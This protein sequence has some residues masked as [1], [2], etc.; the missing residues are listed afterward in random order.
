[1]KPLLLSLL[2]ILLAAS[3]IKQPG[4]SPDPGPVQL[5]TIPEEFKAWTMFRP[6]S[7]WIYLN[8]KTQ[9]QDSTVFKHGPFFQEDPYY[10]RT[11]TQRMWFWVR[12][13]FLLEYYARG[14]AAGNATLDV[15]SSWTRDL[16]LTGQCLTDPAH[17]DTATYSYAF[18]FVETINNLVLNG[19][20]F[21]GVLHTRNTWMKGYG[22]QKMMSA[23]YYWA[24]GTGLIKTR[25]VYANT[26]T[27]WSLTGWK[28]V[29]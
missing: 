26:D 22:R 20:S 13:P 11:V 28:T 27:T 7:W 2:V 10:N 25:R 18:T 23:D 3:C 9:Q 5:L 17:A 6:G 29:Q 8:E 24:R 1:M 14:G 21:P 16:A 19:H 4:P 12:S 15:I